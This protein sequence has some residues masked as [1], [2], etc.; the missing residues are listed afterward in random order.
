MIITILLFI[1]GFALLIKGADL[2]VDGAVSVAKKFNI[3]NLVIGLT[4]VAFGT[5]APEFAVSVFSSVSGN[6]DIAIGNIIGSNVANI[7]LILGAA[8]LVYPLSVKGG[9]VWKEIPMA[10]LA[11]VLVGFMAND[12]LINGEA[13]NAITRIDG[14]I[15]LSFFIIF[16]Y[17]IY[18]IAKSGNGSDVEEVNEMPIGRSIV[19]VGAGLLALVVGGK[20]I[21]DGA[22]AAAELLGVRQSVIGLTVVAIGTSLPELATSVVAAYRKHTDI[23]IGNVVGSNIFN[24]FWIMGISSVINP[25]PLQPGSNYDIGMMIASSVVLFV[26]LFIGKRH[27]VERW[28]G[29]LFLVLYCAYIASLIL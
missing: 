22:V 8:A 5:S 25:L 17:Y 21:V 10:L 18:G 27:V 29:I 4:V 23:A 26:I 16:L 20:W 2:L 9:T 15:L 7:L 1:L 13:K 14:L 6:T 24:V 19:F 11:A 3:S 28:Q 12:V